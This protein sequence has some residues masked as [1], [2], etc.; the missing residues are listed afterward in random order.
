MRGML[1]DVLPSKTMLAV[2]DI[3]VK[4]TNMSQSKST[5]NP[6][7]RTYQ[8]YCQLPWEHRCSLL[9]TLF[10]CILLHLNI[11]SVKTDYKNPFMDD[12]GFRKVCGILPD[13]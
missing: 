5:G 11:E 3:T 6:S 13:L 8:K 10:N 12:S 4:A 1:E 7:A 9:L 2:N